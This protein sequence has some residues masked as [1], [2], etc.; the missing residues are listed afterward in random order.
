[1]IQ[2][3]ILYL[4]M[5]GITETLQRKEP[6]PYEMEN[7]YYYDQSGKMQPLPLQKKILLPSTL[8]AKIWLAEAKSQFKVSDY[9]EH[10]SET[11]KGYI[12]V[13][14]DN[15]DAF[16][17][18][19]ELREKKI[20]YQPIVKYDTMEC[21][22]LDII[23]FIPHT[24]VTENTLKKRLKQAY[25][26]EYSRL[27][28]VG[29]QYR[30]DGVSK[31]NPP[32]V[33]ALSNLMAEDTAWFKNVVV[34]FRPINSP[35]EA[36]LTTTSPGADLSFRRDVK[37]TIKVYHEKAGVRKDL[38][39]KLGQGG[40]V[41][42][43]GAPKDEVWY[44]FEEPVVT[45]YSDNGVTTIELTYRFKF[46]HNR[47]FSVPGIHVVY[48]LNG[49][50]HT[51]PTSPVIFQTSSLIEDT[52][53]DDIQPIRWF[54]PIATVEQPAVA[55][56][57][58]I[59][60]T[61]AGH[62]GVGIGGTLFVLALLGIGVGGIRTVMATRAANANKYAPVATMLSLAEELNSG[63]GKE[64]WKPR[65]IELHAAVG[66][67]VFNFCGEK[68]PQASET[69]EDDEL[70]RSILAELEKAYMPPNTAIPEQD[71]LFRLMKRFVERSYYE[72]V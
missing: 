23:R 2:A 4:A 31:C 69:V 29:N 62:I 56:Q 21:V 63:L 45:E 3:L 18:M 61:L 44:D 28:K 34:M 36:F 17:I 14:K 37:L 52:N 66:V 9:H 10:K 5:F 58:A 51:A 50:E 59:P 11:T 47:P 13:V 41:P 55:N 35:V 20:P 67:V 38:L 19:A 42:A 25:G 48:E 26:L 16:N 53:I 33:L 46:L 57:S 49:K 70:L 64:D 24:A 71:K 15:R 43:E 6:A 54:P 8:A 12:A 7:F 32:N 60:W 65:Y 40:W 72:Y 39:P 1:M 30:I 27:R 68:W 22:P